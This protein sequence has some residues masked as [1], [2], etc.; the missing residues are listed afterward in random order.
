MIWTSP[1]AFRVRGTAGGTGSGRFCRENGRVVAD[2]RRTAAGE[3]SGSVKRARYYSLLLT[4]S[5]VRRRLF[6]AILRRLELLP[7]L[8]W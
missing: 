2:Q 4:E 6:G 8:A 3:H 7:L 5:H 1:L